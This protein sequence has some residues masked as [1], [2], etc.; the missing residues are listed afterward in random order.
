MLTTSPSAPTKG[1][2][3]GGP[4]DYSPLRG[5]AEFFTPRP[6]VYQQHATIGSTRIHDKLQARRDSGGSG[7]PMPRNQSRAIFP[8]EPTQGNGGRQ[9]NGGQVG[10]D[11]AM[12]HLFPA[13]SPFDDDITT[14][15]ETRSE[16]ALKT[17]G[18]PPGL[19]PPRPAT[20]RAMF[21]PFFPGDGE[22]K[23]RSLRPSC[24]TATS[25]ASIWSTETATQQSPFSPSPAPLDTSS[26]PTGDIRGYSG[27]VSP[28]DSM[29]LENKASPFDSMRAEGKAPNVFSLQ[30]LWDD[31][32]VKQTSKAAH[33]SYRYAD[34]GSPSLFNNGAPAA[35]LGGTVGAGDGYSASIMSQSIVGLPDNDTPRFETPVEA[36]V[37]S[38]RPGLPLVGSIAGIA[39]YSND[40]LSIKEIEEKMSSLKEQSSG[41]A[42]ELI[43]QAAK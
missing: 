38:P 26:N 15:P 28:F 37:V 16:I 35:T 24:Q 17:L 42:G 33:Q 36:P 22:R 41:L 18:P 30:G 12:Y 19:A 6:F 40:L 32:P 39:G 10:Q 20:S 3:I 43:Q 1:S 23:T 31:S 27:L 29:R 8:A 13:F 4:S 9:D 11:D 21:S 25:A 2:G 34:R 14:L 7:I 5:D